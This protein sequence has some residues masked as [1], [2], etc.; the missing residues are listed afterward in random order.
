M[1]KKTSH[2]SHKST[3]K[4]KYERA[5]LKLLEKGFDKTLSGHAKFKFCYQNPFIDYENIISS[6]LTREMKVLEIG[7]GTGNYTG[8]IAK[9]GAKVIASDISLNSLEV[10][11]ILNAEFDNIEFKIADI[12][13]LPFESDEFDAIL[14]SG[15]L[16]YGEFIIVKQELLRVLKKGGLLICVDALND[17]P[18]YRLKRLIDVFRG[19]RTYMTYKN[20][21][22]IKSI[23]NLLEN[24]EK[25]E[26]KFFGSATWVL[27]FFPNFSK[28]KYLSAFIDELVKCKKSAFY[29]SLVAKKK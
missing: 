15:S 14:S 7:A 9:T 29:F 12:E 26:I 18:I 19:K 3:E 27:S 10:S 28:I 5:S 1:F 17:N 13:K 21:P 24:F 11:K 23:E 16:S 6:S 4:D 2:N 20:I 25:S 22:T 8:Q